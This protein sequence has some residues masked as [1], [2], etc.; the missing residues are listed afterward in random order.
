VTDRDLWER[1]PA[2]MGTTEHGDNNGLMD[3]L[4]VMGIMSLQP[5]TVAPHTPIIEAAR[6]L[7]AHRVGALLVVESGVL[8][9]ILTK[10]DLIDALIEQ[11]ATEATATAARS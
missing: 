9:G 8:L 1:I 10:S 2:G 4:R 3:H 6:L 7:R 11:S 5:V